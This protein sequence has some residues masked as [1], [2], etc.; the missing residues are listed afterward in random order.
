VGI[1]FAEA[2]R[3]DE[4]VTPRLQPFPPHA[5]TIDPTLQLD[6]RTHAMIPVVQRQGQ[7]EFR[8]WLIQAYGGR[9][10]ITECDAVEA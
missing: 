5:L 8:N 6:E 3:L 9:C 4:L 10:A 7:P 1:T 2:A